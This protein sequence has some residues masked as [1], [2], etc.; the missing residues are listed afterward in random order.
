MKYE[1]VTDLEEISQYDDLNLEENKI[2]NARYIHALIDADKGN[3]YIEALPLPRSEN[4]ITRVY[5]K[6]LL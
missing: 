1:Y 2:V 5:T 4:N 3:P 6:T